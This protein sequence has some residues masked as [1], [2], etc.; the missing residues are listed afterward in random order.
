M[1][2]ASVLQAASARDFLNAGA[3]EAAP[4]GRD[5]L[6][7]AHCRTDSSPARPT[8]TSNWEAGRGTRP[9]PFGQRGTESGLRVLAGRRRV[10]TDHRTHTGVAWDD[11]T[12]ARAA[13]GVPRPL[14]GRRV[15]LLLVGFGVRPVA[16]ALAAV[17]V[18]ARRPTPVDVGVATVVGPGRVASEY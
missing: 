2:L 9:R 12:A 3:L 15:G 11:G 7:L 17:A 1:L 5:L 14:R 4:R 10:A 13:Y 18:G 8:K 16:V 6:K